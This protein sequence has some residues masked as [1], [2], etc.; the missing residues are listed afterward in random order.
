[1]V[2]VNVGTLHNVLD[3]VYGAFKINPLFFSRG[4]GG[5]KLKLLERMIRQLF[6]EVVG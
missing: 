1:M 5:L 2:S 3:Q 4:W 6:P